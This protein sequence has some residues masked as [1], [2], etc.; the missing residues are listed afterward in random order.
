M[1][2]LPGEDGYPANDKGN[3]AAVC[4]R[5][6]RGEIADREGA[7]RVVGRAGGEG[8]AVVRTVSGLPRG[9]VRQKANALFEKN[10]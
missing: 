1:R 7:G 10:F 4:W 9:G 2:C 8:A 3:R 5:L 6:L